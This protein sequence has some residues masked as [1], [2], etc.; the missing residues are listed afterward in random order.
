MPEFEFVTSRL[1]SAQRALATASVATVMAIVPSICKAA[2]SDV[3]FQ[4]MNVVS[5]G[6][7]LCTL[8]RDGKSLTRAMI[9]DS[10]DHETSFASFTVD[11]SSHADLTIVCQR[12]G[13]ELEAK[14]LSVAPSRWIGDNA[15]CIPPQNYA[16]EEKSEACKDY[17]LSS[18]W[19]QMQY[20]PNVRL[21]LRARS[22]LSE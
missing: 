9:P 13:F 16:A 7:A 12:N 17:P 10:V 1:Q 4:Q 2:S 8:F 3:S 14:V 21:A 5:T 6:G 20:P 22:H 18:S 19:I 15:P 11:L